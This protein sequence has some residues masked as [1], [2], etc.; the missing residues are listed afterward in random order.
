[1]AYSYRYGRP[2]L[3]RSRRGIIFGVCRGTAE[4]FDIS[5]F[6]TRAAAVIALIATGLWPIGGLYLL[7]ALL[8]K[9]DPLYRY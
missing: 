2:G 3:Y 8:M 7:A 1:M 4:Y 9:P 6:W 5:V